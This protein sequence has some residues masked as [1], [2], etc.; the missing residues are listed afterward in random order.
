MR[1]LG[2][3]LDRLTLKLA[4]GV[5]LLV[6]VPIGAGLYLLS[7]QQYDRAFEA[8]Q[9]A[10][11]LQ[12][13]ILET[14]VRH[15][16]M[17]NDSVL[18]GRIVDEIGAQPEVRRAMILDHD[19][20]IR[21]SS[22]AARVGQ[23]ISRDDET[24]R[25]CHAKEP[26][27]RPRWVLLN[28]GSHGVLRSVLPIQNR[29]ECWSCHDRA[30]KLTG[31]LVLDVSLAELESDFRLDLAW[32]LFGGGLLALLVLA[33]VG[34]L[35]RHLIL[36]RLARLSKAARTMA[37]GDL[38]A[39]AETG[40]NDVI[41]ELAG[42]FNEMARA[43]AGLV[44]EL[45]GQ[46]SQ[47]AS[48][49]NSLDDGLVVLDR[50]SK[51][52]AV[53]RSFCRRADVDPVDLRG[54][55]C[56]EAVSARLPC[57]AGEGEC[58]AIR[59][60]ATGQV[61]RAVFQ[62]NEGSGEVSRVEEVYASPVT[63]GEGRVVQ[64]V[65]LWRDISERVKEEQR[66]AEIERLVSLGVLASGFSHEVNTPLASMLTSAEA[67][68]ARID[69]SARRGGSP[70]AL[71]PPL[72]EHADVIRGQVLRCRKVTE[73]FL[74]FSRGIPPSVEPLDL[75]A[76]V[77]EV[78]AL[79][80]PTAREAGVSLSL[81]GDGPLPA[82]RANA[83]VVQHAVLNLLV[84]SVQSCHGRK[85]SVRVSFAVNGAVLVD[86]KDTGCGIAPEDRRHLFEPFRSRKPQGTGLGL[87][88]SRTFLRRF[89]G[90]V[91]LV[92]SE[93]GVGSHFQVVFALAEG[94]PP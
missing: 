72:R 32:I 48:V 62:V 31:M 74:R 18:L 93:V 21:I 22:E 6:I 82:V 70:A 89:G 76:K 50:E 14:A 71:L 34:L 19:G 84:N 12:N 90:D 41:T 65:E 29:P 47:L 87:F 28:E 68:L 37:R 92:E 13:Q 56:G 10:A 15:Q 81:D 24:C 43:V 20:E 61:E 86:V 73:Q 46:E 7:R 38:A 44:T 54:R 9:R 40:G 11:E 80:R 83:E 53:N 66:L 27:A 94:G 60:A 5:A 39:R 79:V 3:P 25:V 64:V 85:G 57:G 51:I 63:D 23:K 91:R 1:V 67:I 78:V 4:V 36:R 30:Q 35:V 52:V 69:E 16:M 45:R 17:E 59:C 8:R 2:L 88:L 55:R 26:G 58:P 75:A 42:D 77:A 33:G 49:M